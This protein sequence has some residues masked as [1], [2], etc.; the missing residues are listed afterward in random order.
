MKKFF[1]I[2]GIIFLLLI[3]AI[4]GFTLYGSQ[5]GKKLD[6]ESKNFVDTTMP[7]I[8]AHWSM[9][10]F[11]KYEDKK[12]MEQVG[13]KEEDLKKFFLIYSKLGKMI[14]Y[15]GSKGQSNFFIGIGSRDKT[16][17]ATYVANADFEKASATINLTLIK[18][19]N[20]WEIGGIKVDSPYFLTTH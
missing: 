19:N 10:E 16:P 7:K 13:V 4:G 9:E 5:Q 17:T 11:E 6:A 1:A 3:L 18:E 14:K 12:V 20:V 2:L 8:L 15:N